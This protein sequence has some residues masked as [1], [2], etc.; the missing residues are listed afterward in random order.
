M[1]YRELP[2]Q[3]KNRLTI[4]PDEWND[5]VARAALAGIRVRAQEKWI[6]FVVIDTQREYDVVARPVSS[7]IHY[8]EESLATLARRKGLVHYGDVSSSEAADGTNVPR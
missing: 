5:L 6:S 2:A 3:F 7:S 1:M 4:T 8:L